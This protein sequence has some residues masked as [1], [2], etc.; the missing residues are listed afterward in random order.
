MNINVYEF[1]K[2]KMTKFKELDEKIT[3]LQKD[4]DT[5]NKAKH[6]PYFALNFSD[7]NVESFPLHTFDKDNKEFK[8]KIQKDILEFV[9]NNFAKEMDRLQKEIESI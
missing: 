6:V 4:I 3:N 5:L 9:K 8:D 1:M 2:I 7:S